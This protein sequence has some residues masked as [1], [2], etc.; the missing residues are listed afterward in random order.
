M[1]AEASFPIRPLRERHTW[2]AFALAAMMHGLLAAFLFYGIH[3]QSSTP[4]GADAELWSAVPDKSTPHATP[5]PAPQMRNEGADIALQEK[6]RRQR[7][8][9]L[10]TQLAKRQRREQLMQEPLADARKKVERQNELKVKQAAEQ[11]AQQEVEQERKARVKALQA[12][13]GAGGNELATTGTGARSGDNAGASY[14]EKVRRR[15]QPNLVFAGD[16]A[17]N[18]STLVAIDCAPDG[19]V[20]NARIV[21]PSGNPG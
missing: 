9:Q 10:Q 21:R 18:I 8:A 2:G 17:P 15:V 7:Q 5:T 19:S 16:A 11:A 3:W 12:M 20:L 13:A 1:N 14:G 6:Q 4:T